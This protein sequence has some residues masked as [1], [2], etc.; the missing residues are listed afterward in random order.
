MP[1]FKHNT[2][3]PP[4]PSPPQSSSPSGRFRSTVFSRK[5]DNSDPYQSQNRYHDDNQTN[6]SHSNGGGF[7]SRRRSSS[8]SSRSRDFKNEPSILAA[9]QKVSDAETS[10]R[11]ADRALGNARAAVREARQHVQMLER[12]ALED[13]RRAKAKQAEAKTVSKSAKGLGRHG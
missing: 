9:R 4:P 10:E 6:G 5:R 3:S 13:A 7:F 11:D 1:L 8:S 12:E 2:P